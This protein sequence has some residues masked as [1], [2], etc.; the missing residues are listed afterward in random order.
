MARRKNRIPFRYWIEAFKLS[1]KEIAGIYDKLPKPDLSAFGAYFRIA[2]NKVFMPRLH[3]ILYDTW[4]KTGEVTKEDIKRAIVE[5]LSTVT[6]EDLVEAFRSLGLENYEAYA[7]AA[8]EILR[9]I[10]AELRARFGLPAKAK[11]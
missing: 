4:K 10:E 1:Q 5:A 3:K 7:D 9:K 6:K 11:A 8:E 2:L